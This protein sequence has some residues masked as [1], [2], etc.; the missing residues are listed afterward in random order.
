METPR[1][2]EERENETLEKALEVLAEAKEAQIKDEKIL[3]QN[4]L[5]R[6]MT[7]DPEAIVAGGAPRDWERDRCCNDIDIFLRSNAI[8][9]HEV[10]AQIEK[11]MTV[12]FNSGFTEDRMLG[13]SDQERISE[14]DIRTIHM[15]DKLKDITCEE[16]YDNSNVRAIFE[17]EVIMEHDEE[18]RFTA[19]ESFLRTS[20]KVQFII[21]KEISP[22]ELFET[23]D[24]SIN[25]IAWK[26]EE[27]P[28]A[29]AEKFWFKIA[30][31]LYELTKE[32]EIIKFTEAEF[33]K[34]EPKEKLEPWQPKE[35]QLHHNKAYNRFVKDGD[36]TV[37]NEMQM[38]V[39]LANNHIRGTNDRIHSDFPEGRHYDDLPF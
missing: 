12:G 33:K 11:A 15:Q 16:Q 30:S 8:S 35:G 25:M 21:V 32:T 1:A 38:A 28:G 14:L 36:Y 31:T 23:F 17:V 29:D 39:Y 18:K 5:L 24:C 20:K 19:D 26:V 6:V 4:V 7:I 13:W 27:Y 2:Q 34:G 3:A 9:G 10:A 22:K 37:G